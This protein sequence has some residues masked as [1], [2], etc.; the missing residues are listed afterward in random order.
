MTLIEYIIGGVLLVLAIALVVI[1]GLQQ[2]KRHGLGNSIAGNGASESYLTKNKIANK[3]KFRQKLT[4]GVAIA[5]VVL[6][7]T[8]YV[9]G[10]IPESKDD[11]SKA[12]ETSVTETSAQTK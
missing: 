10:T 5:F 3:D 1:I 11:T 7:L 6:V 8:L 2:S 12:P 4:L 9:V